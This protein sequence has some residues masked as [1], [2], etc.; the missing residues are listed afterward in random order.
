[1]E[2][3]F[4]AAGF[5][6]NWYTLTLGEIKCETIIPTGLERRDPTEEEAAEGFVL[7]FE[8]A[9]LNASIKVK[10][11]YLQDFENLDAIGAYLKE[12]NP[13]TILQFGTFNG[14]DALLNTIAETEQVNAI[15]ALGDHHYVQIL[16]TPGSGNINMIPLLVASVQF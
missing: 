14:T 9:E 13:D 4:V 12:Q 1:M 10:D 7:V 3:T 16:Y 8:N 6:G 11:S 2:Q 15:F 5:E